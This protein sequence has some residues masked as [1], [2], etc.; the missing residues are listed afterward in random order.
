MSWEI[1]TITS[2]IFLL[3]VC[4]IVYFWPYV[5]IILILMG[6]VIYWVRYFLINHIAEKQVKKILS[7]RK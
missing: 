7:K 2:S 4:L 6:L 1:E 5:F 3:F